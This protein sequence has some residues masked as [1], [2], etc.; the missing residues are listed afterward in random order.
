MGAVW[1]KWRRVKCKADN[2]RRRGRNRELNGEEREVKGMAAE[3][4][5]GKEKKERKRRKKERWIQEESKERRSKQRV[6]ILLLSP[7]HHPPLLVER[8]SPL[9]LSIPLE[10]LQRANTLAPVSLLP[11]DSACVLLFHFSACKSAFAY[12][13]ISFLTWKKKSIFSLQR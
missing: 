11:P 9:L 6:R 12:F 10:H 5:R 3:R 13:P 7:V 1:E 8:H 4:Q 2:S